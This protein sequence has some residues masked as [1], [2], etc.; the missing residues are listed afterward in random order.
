M[1]IFLVQV[2][3]KKWIFF[4]VQ[5][6]WILSEKD[7]EL[8]SH[9]FL[10]DFPTCSFNVAKYSFVLAFIIFF[11]SEVCRD[12]HLS[13]GSWRAVWKV[14]FC[15]CGLL[16]GDA[17]GIARAD[18]CQTPQ[19]CRVTQHAFLAQLLSWPLERLYRS[20]WFVVVLFV[21]LVFWKS[22]KTASWFSFV[23]FHI[24]FGEPR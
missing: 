1:F 12:L 3:V 17:G 7:E 15:V 5:R 23:C 13:A 24:I 20:C 8:W 10:T 6:R 11:S 4:I 2:P 21:C 19:P 18:L 9:Y 16:P 14:C 22:V